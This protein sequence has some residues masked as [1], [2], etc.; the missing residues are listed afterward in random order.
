V[1]F[2]MPASLPRTVSASVD[3]D[4]AD[5]DPASLH[6]LKQS[7]DDPWEDWTAGAKSACANT[8]DDDNLHP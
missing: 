8:H 7:F 5:Y 2:E 4:P 1:T 3:Y 6:Y